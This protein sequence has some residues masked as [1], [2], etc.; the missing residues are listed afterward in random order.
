MRNDRPD[1][2]NGDDAIGMPGRPPPKYRSLLM[3]ACGTVLRKIFPYSAFQQAQMMDI[4]RLRPVTLSRP[5]SRG[6]DCP[7]FRLDPLPPYRLIPPT[8]DSNGA[9]EMDLEQPCFERRRAATVALDVDLGDG[10]YLS[11]ARERTL[12]DRRAP[13][14]AFGRCPAW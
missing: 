4:T 6:M 13:Q 14:H 7:I 10:R 3:R 5:S 2:V 12:V 8:M 11:G 9:R 1:V